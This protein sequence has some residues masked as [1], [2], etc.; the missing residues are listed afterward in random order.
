M[1][2]RTEPQSC[3][4]SPRCVANQVQAATEDRFDN[5]CCTRSCGTDEIVESPVTNI[6]I[7]PGWFSNTTV[8]SE[9][10]GESGPGA[11][12]SAS[13]MMLSS[14]SWKWSTSSVTTWLEAATPSVVGS[15]IL[16]RGPQPCSDS[17]RCWTNQR[18]TA[19]EARFDTA[20]GSLNSADGRLNVA[21]YPVGCNFCSQPNLFALNPKF[22]HTPPKPSEISSV[23][24]FH[25]E[26]NTKEV[27]AFGRSLKLDRTP[28]KGAKPHTLAKPDRPKDP[29]KGK[30]DKD[31][32][33]KSGNSTGGD[34]KLQNKT[35]TSISPNI[36]EAI[37]KLH[38]KNLFQEP[39][40]QSHEE[41]RLQRKNARLM[42]M[43][44]SLTAQLST[45]SA[46]ITSL[47]KQ[48][49][50]LNSNII[51]LTHTAQDRSASNPDLYP[52]SENS[53]KRRRVFSPAK[54]ASPTAE[55]MDHTATLTSSAQAFNF[56]PL[57]PPQAPALPP[58]V[59]NPTVQVSNY[60]PP[61]SKHPPAFVKPTQPKN[62][63]GPTNYSAPAK[64]TVTPEPSTSAGPQVQPQP[65]QDKIPPIIL[66][67]KSRWTMV[68]GAIT[69]LGFSF[70]KAVNTQ[71]GVTSDDYR[72]ITKF[73][74]ENGEEYHT[75][76]LQEEKTLQVV[77][78]GLPLEIAISDIEND[79]IDHKYRPTLV[80]RMRR[81]QLK[82]EMPLATNISEGI[83]FYPCTVIDYRQITKFL[84]DNKEQFHTYRLE[85]ERNLQVVF[86]GLPLEKDIKEVKMT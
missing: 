78:R 24:K 12:R 13:S 76:M 80:T 47:Q 44:E 51:Y 62:T 68:S 79:L 5:G 55:L 30:K 66:R 28:V 52:N 6:G 35:K 64:T 77:I 42:G 18:R 21:V 69:K 19:T 75:F 16:K 61:T 4:D 37:A 48:I 8:A 10:G 25:A 27:P 45:Q 83:K 23:E 14:A 60:I 34:S 33:K 43:V 54:T 41:I 63:P 15:D 22:H 73:L 9:D 57:P 17:S 84:D 32:K 81:G 31:K 86:R 58:A 56:R 49:D 2:S 36:E 7:L 53:N 29:K 50:I 85:E 71:D 1:S 67:Q 70:S 59:T 74:S 20:R 82:T 11:T 39:K 3:S 40:I 26:S 46:Q 65:K 72:G 38:S